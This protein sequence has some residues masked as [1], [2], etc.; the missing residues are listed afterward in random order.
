MANEYLADAK[1]CMKRASAHLIKDEVSTEAL[2]DVLLYFSLGVERLFKAILHEIN[3][4][5]VLESQD[6]ENAASVLYADKLTPGMQKKL[7]AD[8]KKS[9]GP[10]SK[11]LTFVAAMYA[12]AK[13]S[14]TVQDNTATFAHL[15]DLRNIVA[16]HRLS[17]LD[18]GAACRFCWKPFY[19]TV[20][21]PEISSAALAASTHGSWHARQ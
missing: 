8:V 13:F 21:L 15:A 9:K 4:I 11:V 18:A 10:N 1:Y 3:P 5:F 17:Q 14:I 2:H 7:E 20:A 12:A 19:P 6:F 16:H